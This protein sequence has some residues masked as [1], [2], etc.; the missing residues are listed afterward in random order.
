IRI[1]KIEAAQVLGHSSIAEKEIAALRAQI[2]ALPAKSVTVMDARVD[3]ARCEPDSFWKP[4]IADGLAFLRH[5]I[6]PL[7]RVVSQTDF[8]GM[9]FEKDL[10]EASLAQLKG[11][12]EK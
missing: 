11:E 7:F 9:R 12:N 3:L 8:K 10:L 1:D 4:L 2:A 6:Q 5:A